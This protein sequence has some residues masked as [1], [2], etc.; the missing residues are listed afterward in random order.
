MSFSTPRIV[1]STVC[2]DN[3]GYALE[4]LRAA[5]RGGADPPGPA[6]DTNGGSF[7]D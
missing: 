5:L 1:S 6:R 3:D 7:P 2:S 4:S